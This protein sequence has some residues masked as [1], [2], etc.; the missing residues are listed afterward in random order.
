[1]EQPL[2]YPAT[3]APLDAEESQLMDPDNWDWDNPIEGPT[4]GDPG[5]ILR[6]RF[7]FGEVDALFQAARS[8]RAYGS[9][10][11]RS[12]GRGASRHAQIAWISDCG[13]D[14]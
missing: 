5:A 7:T 3:Q 4:M 10:G 12:R 2:P 11:P 6:I 8:R 13:Q 1:M 9:V 14:E